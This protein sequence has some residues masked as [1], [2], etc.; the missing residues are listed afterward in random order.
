[1]IG[2]ITKEARVW[3]G[4]KDVWWDLIRS[5]ALRMTK[6]GKWSG[7]NGFWLNNL[8]AAATAEKITQQKKNGLWTQKPIGINVA[9]GAGDMEKDYPN[10]VE[11]LYEHGDF[12][13]LNFSCP[14]HQGLAEIHNNV[15]KIRAT[16]KAV[17]KINV[18]NKPIVVKFGILSNTPDDINTAQD[19]TYDSLKALIEMC[20]EEL[21]ENQ[22]KINITNTAKE[23]TTYDQNKK[24]EWLQDIKGNTIAWWVSW[25]LIQDRSLQTVQFVKEIIDKNGSKLWIIGTGGIWCDEAWQTGKQLIAMKDAWAELFNM[26]TGFVYNPTSLANNLRALDK[27]LRQ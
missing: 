5:D 17:K 3:N 8:W 6:D 18:A 20:I 7:L 14:N 10:I 16:I 23:H 1:M 4:Y 25:K 22:D 24:L 27:N 13:E 2:G 15:E 26:F 12:F 9:A 19:L 21:D 11:T